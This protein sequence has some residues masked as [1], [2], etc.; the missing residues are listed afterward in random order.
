MSKVLLKAETHQ[1][2]IEIPMTQ[3]KALA[4]ARKLFKNHKKEMANWVGGYSSHT[5][6]RRSRSVSPN[7]KYVDAKVAPFVKVE[8]IH[9]EE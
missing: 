3:A 4:F 9:I 2:T 6:N 8:F 7:Y 1:G 5:W